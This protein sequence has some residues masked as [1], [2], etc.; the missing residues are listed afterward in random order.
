[1]GAGM[2]KLFGHEVCGTKANRLIV[3][4]DAGEI[5]VNIR[6][7]GFIVVNAYDGDF[8]WDAD[9]FSCANAADVIGDLV[10]CGKDPAGLG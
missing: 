5:R 8:I 10:I 3:R 1:M 6:T 4:Q 7:D 9:A 2:E